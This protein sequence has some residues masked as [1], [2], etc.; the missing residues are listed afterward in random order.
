MSDAILDTLTQ[1]DL[2]VSYAPDDD[3]ETEAIVDADTQ[4]GLDEVRLMTRMIREHQ[5]QIAKLAK[6]RKTRVMNLRRAKVT[7]REIAEAMET[8]EQTVFNIIRKDA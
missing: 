7:Y 1:S 8:S 6:K 5:E 2:D 3:S 4:R